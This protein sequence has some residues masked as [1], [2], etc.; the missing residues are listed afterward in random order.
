MEQRIT[1]IE[2]MRKRIDPLLDKLNAYPEIR[3]V[4]NSFL[5]SLHHKLKVL[6]G[7]QEPVRMTTEEAMKEKEDKWI[8][9]KG[10]GDA[11]TME[12]KKEVS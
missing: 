6:K 2:G 5:S 10:F 4:F 3:E 12:K 7:Q 1:Q 8:K 11:K 9:V